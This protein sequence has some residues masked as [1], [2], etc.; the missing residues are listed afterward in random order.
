MAKSQWQVYKKSGALQINIAGP[1]YERNEKGFETI[2]RHGAVFV[3]MG[4]GDNGVI[5]WENKILFAIG[6]N[7]IGKLLYAFEKW[8]KSGVIELALDHF[9]A[10]KNK[11]SFTIKNGTT[12]TYMVGSFYD[13]K[14]ASLFFDAGEMLYFE[15]IIKRSATYIMLGT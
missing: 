4:K 12:G 8:K 10:D 6:P 13:G 11:K 5:D 7:D 2:T 9:D 1:Q 15:Q 3:D 14:S